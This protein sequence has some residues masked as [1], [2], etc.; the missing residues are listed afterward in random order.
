LQKIFS[1]E[2]AIGFVAHAR[3]FGDVA[4]RLLLRSQ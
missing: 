3:V 4:A 1:A 2:P